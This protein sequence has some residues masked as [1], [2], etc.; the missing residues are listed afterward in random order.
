MKKVFRISLMA[1]ATVIFTHVQAQKP[2]YNSL[3]W[4]ISGNGLNQS[5]YLYG[6]HHL[7]CPQDFLLK[8]KTLAAFKKSNQLIVEVNLSDTAELNSFQRNLLKAE[9]ISNLLTVN[10]EQRLDTALR[11]YY[12]LNYEQVKN[13]STAILSSLIIQKT[14]KCTDIKNPEM[15]LIK[16]AGE[17]NKPVE[18]LE[19][20]EE[21]LGFLEKAFSASMLVDQIE[22]TPHYTVL[23]KKLLD[24]YKVENLSGFEEIF[25][26]QLYMTP[27]AAKWMLTIRNNS[28]VKKMPAI[29]NA[30]STFFAVG[31]AHLIGEAGVISLLRKQGYTVKA[32]IQ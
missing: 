15:E 21:Q 12:S 31:A 29:M 28:W 5:S 17:Q 13:V 1:I 6:T 22:Q 32:I 26:D 20:A 8:E 30:E 25:S 4:E 14:I 7:L 11:K 16:L 9:K 10:E 2:L 24:D 3:L 19:N 27:E 23:S 18:Q